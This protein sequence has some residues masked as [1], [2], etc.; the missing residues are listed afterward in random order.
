MY[1]IGSEGVPI[2]M[3]RPKSADEFLFYNVKL[4]ISGGHRRIIW[5]VM[6]TPGFLHL[7]SPSQRQED[8]SI[9]DAD[10]KARGFSC[11]LQCCLE[12]NH[13]I[14]TH[15]QPTHKALALL[16]A[17]GKSDLQTTTLASNRGSIL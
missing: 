1:C 2:Q 7:R 5:G 4:A 3:G 6:N 9:F 13:W 12:H 16:G 15:C 8:S 17:R 11:F 10:L 14:T